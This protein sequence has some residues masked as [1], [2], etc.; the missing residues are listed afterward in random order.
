MNRIGTEVNLYLNNVELTISTTKNLKKESG[1]L[2]N[3]GSITVSTGKIGA[4]ECF[5]DNL[6]YFFNISYEDF[7]K[8]CRSELREKGF[9]TKETYKDIQK[10]LK[11]AFK[12]KL[13]A[14]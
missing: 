14:K 4:K 1:N 13:L 9:K 7:R 2:T 6:E 12:L 5:W 11:R 10:L 3:F 8:E